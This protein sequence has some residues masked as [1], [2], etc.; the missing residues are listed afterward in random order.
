MKRQEKSVQERE[1]RRQG[2]RRR[3]EERSK[4]NT[5]G[6]IQEEREKGWMTPRWKC[7]IKP[8][9]I[10]GREQ[11]KD[12]GWITPRRRDKGRPRRLF[13]DKQK[14]DEDKNRQEKSRNINKIDEEKGS[15]KEE[16]RRIKEE[17]KTP[18][19]YTSKQP[20]KLLECMNRYE[21]LEETDGEK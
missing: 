19:R 17:T 16:R 7:T 20:K 5:E 6:A 2:D 8:R 11:K 3:Q 12:D 15:R 13:E 14:K 21:I 1:E 4:C 10:A 9:R 18:R